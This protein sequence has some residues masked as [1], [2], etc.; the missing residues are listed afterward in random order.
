MNKETVVD[1]VAEGVC[2]GMD[3]GV[4]RVSVL[5]IG[6]VMKMTSFSYWIFESCKNPETGEGTH[7]P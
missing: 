7:S 1:L 3:L 5:V 4:I 6:P 2:I